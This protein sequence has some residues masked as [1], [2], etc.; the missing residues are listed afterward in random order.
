M[1]LLFQNILKSK[2]KKHKTSSGTEKKNMTSQSPSSTL[3]LKDSTRYFRH[4]YSIKLSKNKMD[5]KVIKYH[6]CSAERSHTVLIEL[7][8]EF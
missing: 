8:F 6:Q 2:S 4:R 3:Y 5:L 1:Y 7:D